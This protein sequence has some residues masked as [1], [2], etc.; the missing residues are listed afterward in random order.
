MQNEVS[1]ETI[2]RFY[3]ACP[4]VSI[5]YGI[6]EKAETVY[7]IPGSF[8]WNDVGS[9]KAVHELSD[10]DADGN[11]SIRS[12]SIFVE[13]SDNLVWAE[14]GKKVVLSGVKNLGV[15]ETGDAILIVDLNRAQ[16][17]KKVVDKLRKSHEENLL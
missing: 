8:D 1:A 11:A 5:D 6:L 16:T 13:A 12:D 4:S 7:V 14:S 3:R 17:V 15:I 9:W 2:E 10:K